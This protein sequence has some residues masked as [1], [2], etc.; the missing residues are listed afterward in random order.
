MIDAAKIPAELRETPAWCLWKTVPRGG[1]PTKIP[2]RPTD[3]EAESDNPATWCDFVEAWERYKIG[4]Y[5]GIGFMFGKEPLGFVGVDLDA[6][7]DPESGKVADWAREIIV[8]LDSYA[9]VS[10]SNSGVK[11]FMRG[12]SPFTS[13]KNLK[14]PQFGSVGGKEAGIE[15]YDHRRYFA[16]TGMRVRG[17]LICNERQNELDW[18]KGLYWPDAVPTIGGDFYGEDSVLERAR[19]YLAKCPPAISGQNGSG[20]AFHV[21]CILVLGFGLSRDTSLTLFRE[22]NQICQPPWSERELAHKIDDA[23]KQPGTRNFLRNVT[24]AK[25][26]A[27]TV[28]TFADPKMNGR[29]KKLNKTTMVGAAESYIGFIEGGGG[30]AI[31]TGIHELDKA[32]NGGI[33]PGELILVAARPS[34]GKSMLAMQFVHYWST[35]EIPCIFISEEMP[36]VTLGKRAMQ[37]ISERPQH[38]WTAAPAALR[39]ELDRYAKIRAACHIVENCGTVETALAQIEEAM[40]THKVKAAV[41]DY[42]QCL[43]SKGKDRYEQV[44]NTSEALRDFAHQKKIPLIVLCHIGR[45][46]EKRKKF[47]PVMSDLK[48]SGQL[49]QDADVIMFLVWP[50]RLDS[51][52]TP[53]QYQIYVAKNRNRGVGA[54]V[55]LCRFDP[56][57]QM[58]SEIKSANYESAFANFSEP[59]D[60]NDRFF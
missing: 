50:W 58:V 42:A 53:D 6:C 19:K 26:D 36:A 33:E 54:P 39:E 60:E 38:E 22:W 20:A 23:A 9:E 41:I 51:K 17:P 59:K 14:L 31:S 11:I 13:G 55:V 1:K 12:Q 37:F 18:L 21:A 5:E 32:L 40:E 52:Q 57:R 8:K 49:E 4:G 16:V 56:I 25:W 43:K 28:P 15:I 34:H 46:I 48:E 7:R 10:P 24:P 44:T 30:Q 45:D 27:V 29:A 3:Y 35:I 47:I 2:F